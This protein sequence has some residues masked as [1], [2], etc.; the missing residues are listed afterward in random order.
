M[1]RSFGGSSSL[2]RFWVACIWGDLAMDATILT[3]GL[4]PS[5]RR[6]IAA[7][8]KPLGFRVVQMSNGA[9]LIDTAQKEKPR[10]IILGASGHTNDEGLVQVRRI[11]EVGH[12]QPVVLISQ[13][14]CE[15]RATAAFR[16]GVADYFKEP[17]SHSEL[18]NRIGDLLEAETAGHPSAAHLIPPSANHQPQMIGDSALMTAIREYLVRAA[19]TDSTVLITGET[20]TGKELAA[21]M[22]HR[23][24]CRAARP[25]I[26]VNCAALPENLA[27]SELFGYERGA[28]TGALDSR[29]G[30]FALAEDGTIFLDEIGDMTPHIQAKILHA[31]EEKV[32]C[33][34][35]CK[36]P[37]SLNVRVVAATNQDLEQL[38]DDHRF[39]RDLYYRLNIARVHLPPLR[40]RREDIRALVDHALDVLNRRFD[41]KVKGLSPETMAFL[42]EYRWPG[43]VRE[44]MNMLESTYINLYGDEITYTDLPIN[45]RKYADG[46][47][48]SPEAEER[49]VILSALKQTNWNKSLAARKLNWSRMTLYRKMSRLKITETRAA[50]QYQHFHSV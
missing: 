2:F 27:E 9:N 34:L 29:K 17:F 10:I 31:I 8:F 32:I 12:H 13:E 4:K 14:S 18:L 50:N 28:F 41:R 23:H 36:R 40:E 6:H 22:I 33:P 35:G 7:H 38:V 16:A 46:A 26:S 42:H 15:A 21:R 48:N 20:G 45:F 5:H 1:I 37:R 30:K 47:R 39:R 44:L 49:R 43:N 25:L 3:S 24:S 19:T 11:K